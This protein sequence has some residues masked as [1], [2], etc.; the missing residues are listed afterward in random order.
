MLSGV[1]KSLGDSL[2]KTYYVPEFDTLD[3]WFGDIEP[4]TENEEVGDGIILKLGRNREAVGVEIVG[5]SKTTRKDLAGLPSG[6]RK[7][8]LE[9]IKKQ[10]LA[11]ASLS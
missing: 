10:S 11:T 7:T 4:T 8:V 1:R 9:A 6:V 2:V 5:L 3:V